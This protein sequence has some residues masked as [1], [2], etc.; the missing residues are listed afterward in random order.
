M[1]SN[2]QRILT[3]RLLA[4][5]MVPAALL[6]CFTS[7]AHPAVAQQPSQVEANAALIRQFWDIFNTGNLDTIGALIAPDAVQRN[8]PPGST[9]GRAGYLEGLNV[10][11]TGFPD[12]HATITELA[13][14][15]DHVTIR[16]VTRGPNT[17]P[18]SGLPPTGKKVEIESFDEFIISGGVITDAWAIQ[19]R[20]AKLI[21]LGFLPLPPG[22][23]VVDTR[24]ADPASGR[25]PSQ[26][27]AN[28]TLVNQFFAAISA[29]RLSDLAAVVSPT[30]VDHNPAYPYQP[31]GLAGLQQSL[32]IITAFPV[33]QVTVSSLVAQGDTVFARVS[34]SVPLTVTA[35]FEFRIVNGTI[36]DVWH[37]DDHIDALLQLLTS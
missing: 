32:G 22:A 37:L 27:D 35:F 20:L 8:I 21:Q 24:A 30:V 2:M 12:V 13:A 25:Q 6:L 33:G 19:D 5:M 36:V 11:L 23:Y 9:Q 15:G 3:G 7:A 4:V 17:G 10:F 26:P 18:I 1:L 29:G 34:T 31:A 14:E 28:K 16:L